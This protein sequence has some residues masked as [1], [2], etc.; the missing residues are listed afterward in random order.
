ALEESGRF[1]EP[2]VVEIT[3]FESFYRAEEY[4]Q[5]Y[6]RKNPVHYEA[7]ARGSGRKGFLKRIWGDEPLELAGPRSA[8]GD[9]QDD[10][11]GGE[12]AEGARG[13]TARYT[14]PPDDEL[15]RILTPEQYRITQ[16]DGTERAFANEYW[17]NKK[18]GI[19]VDV[20]SGEP[21]FSSRDKYRS[22]T[23]WPSFTRPL[24]PENIVEESDYKLGM[25]RTEVR[26]KHA[27]SHLGHV[28][29]DGP[30]PTGLRYCINSAALRFVPA[31]RLAEE[32]YAEFA[33]AFDGSGSG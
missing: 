14:R 21:L 1:G 8:T 13:E 5:D 4:H 9:G 29:P 17:D 32:G 20:V 2:I 27:D 18:P 28:F 23:G 7:Y 15:R 10:G 22:G 26:S 3:P 30:P 25:R 19:Y 12:D 6:Y 31:D 33:A 16:Q 11:Q 24:V